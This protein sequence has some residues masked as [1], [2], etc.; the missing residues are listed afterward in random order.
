[1]KDTFQINPEYSI[2]KLAN[3]LKDMTVYPLLVSMIKHASEGKTMSDW[4][5]S[6]EMM[7][8]HYYCNVDALKDAK[9]QKDLRKTHSIEQISDMQEDILA[10]VVMMQTIID[11]TGIKEDDLK[12]K[13][14]RFQF[15]LSMEFMRKI[16]AC[17]FDKIIEKFTFEPDV[18]IIRNQNIEEYE[19]GKYRW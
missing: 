19:P 5:D 18:S 2:D 17:T 6:I 15:I 14:S 1:M 11:G 8:C 16:K 4:L 12:E 7:Q 13:I 9:K 10:S 3:A